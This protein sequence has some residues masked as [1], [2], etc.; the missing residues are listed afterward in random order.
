MYTHIISILVFI[1]LGTL[2]L[3]LSHIYIYIYIIH[4]HTY[5]PSLTDIFIHRSSLSSEALHNDAFYLNVTV[6]NSKEVIQKKAKDKV[7][8]GKGLYPIRALMT[9]ITL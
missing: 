2:T 6:L 8:K 7:G 4:T 3:S 5:K 9:L 1:K